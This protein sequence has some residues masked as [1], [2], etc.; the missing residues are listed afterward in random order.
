VAIKPKDTNNL[1]KNFIYY[2]YHVPFSSVL[3]LI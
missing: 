2:S 3:K 1:K